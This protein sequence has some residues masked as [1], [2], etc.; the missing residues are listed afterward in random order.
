MQSA[1]TIGRIVPCDDS[2]RGDINI[3][4][5]ETENLIAGRLEICNGTQWM[6]V[7]ADEVWDSRDVNLVCKEKGFPEEGN[8]CS[9]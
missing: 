4:G 5:I 2:E 6:A 7:Y 1:V 8:H 9:Q 3:I